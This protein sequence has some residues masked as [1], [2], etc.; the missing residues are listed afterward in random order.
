MGNPMVASPAKISNFTIK[1]LEDLGWYKENAQDKPA[2]E[3]YIFHKGTGCGM[4][5]DGKCDTN[6][7]EYCSATEKSSNDHCTVNMMG[8]ARCASNY[9]TDGCSYKAPVGSGLCTLA[10][11]GENSKSFTFEDYGAHSRC[12]MAKNS[13]KF[14]AACLRTRCEK[15]KVE[16]QIGKDIVTCE[17]EGDMMVDVALYKGIVK[18]PSA[19]KMCNDIIADRCPMDCSGNGYCMKSNDPK[20]K[21]Q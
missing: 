19:Q 6:D 20:V 11:Q 16:F 7:E 21:N 14:K 15:G 2:A 3:D 17:K 8:K 18:C 5:K 1:L 9:F 13:N 12:F 10:S 4:A